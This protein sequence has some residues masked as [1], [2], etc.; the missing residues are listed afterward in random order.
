MEI[1]IANGKKA[2]DAFNILLSSSNVELNDQ[3]MTKILQKF[4]LDSEFFWCFEQSFLYL[5]NM[6]ISSVN[7]CFIKFDFE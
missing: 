6:D 7:T 5:K 4:C 3:D 1:I 2:Y